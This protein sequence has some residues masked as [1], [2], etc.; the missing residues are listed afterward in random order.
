MDTTNALKDF[1]E[2]GNACFNC[3][4]FLTCKKVA[5]SGGL[6]CNEHEVIKENTDNEG[7]V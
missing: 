7:T 4:H 6:A 3:V 2:T 5:N 1:K